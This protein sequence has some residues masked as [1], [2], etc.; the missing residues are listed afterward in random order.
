MIT[1][2]ERLGKELG[3]TFAHTTTFTY[4]SPEFYKNMGYEIFG[5]NDEYPDGIKQFFLKK[6]KKD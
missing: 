5:V 4:Q 2:A 6:L 3:C 1:E